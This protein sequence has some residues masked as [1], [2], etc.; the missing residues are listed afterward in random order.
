MIPAK[1]SACKKP[2]ILECV[3]LRLHFPPER[4]DLK[5]RV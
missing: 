5:A 3:K 2:R 4:V 1:S